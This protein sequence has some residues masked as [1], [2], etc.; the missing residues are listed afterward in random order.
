M[1]RL[2]TCSIHSVGCS[3]SIHVI[4]IGYVIIGDEAFIL[5]YEVFLLHA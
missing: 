3:N 1:L 4:V 2:C 5:V